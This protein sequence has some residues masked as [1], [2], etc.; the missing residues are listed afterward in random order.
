[1]LVIVEGIDRVGKTT[2]AKMLEEKM[3]FIYLKDAFIL[4]KYKIHKSHFKDY[5]LG[6]CE[7]SVV[8]LKKLVEDGYNIVMDRLHLTEYVYGQVERTINKEQLIELDQ[9]ISQNI[10]DSL[11]VIVEPTNVQEAILRAGKDL[12]AQEV[13]FKWAYS[14][15][16]INR[17]TCDYDTLH[18]AFHKIKRLAF[19]YDFYFASPFF[20]PEQIEREERLIS[21]L[22][23]YGYSVFSPRESCHL[24]AKASQESRV[25]VFNDNCEAIRNSAAVF[26][27]TDGKDMGTIWEAGYAYGIKRPILYYAETLGDNQFNLMLAQSGKGVFRRLDEVT[28]CNIDVALLSTIEYE[29]DIE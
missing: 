25:K 4:N 6:K 24:D 12:E 29:G 16:S 23:S 17:T 7:S 18:F 15:T 3:G 11:V 13:L 28:P 19:K 8:I 14:W 26:A 1:M 2:L 20:T 5:S 21:H 10:P 22:R 27:I 9:Y